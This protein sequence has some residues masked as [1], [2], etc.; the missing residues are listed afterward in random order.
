MGLAVGQHSSFIHSSAKDAFLSSCIAG[1]T[2]G[3]GVLQR[4][5]QSFSPRKAQILAG[6]MENGQRKAHLSGSD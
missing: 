5:R 1:P 4:L 2:V 3:L 6:K